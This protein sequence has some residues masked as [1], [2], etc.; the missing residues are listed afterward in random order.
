M[1]M[2][3]FFLKVL[4]AQDLKET[5]FVFSN[6]CIAETQKEMK[7]RK[8]LQCHPGAKDIRVLGTQSVWVHSCFSRE[9]FGGRRELTRVWTESQNWALM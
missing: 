7:K 9:Y 4:T 8:N 6:H 5:T 3:C 1:N 2:E